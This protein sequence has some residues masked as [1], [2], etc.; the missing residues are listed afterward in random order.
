MSSERVSSVPTANHGIG[1]LDELQQLT[2]LASVLSGCPTVMIHL[3]QEES[4][5]LVTGRQW[6]PSPTHPELPFCR[7][8]LAQNAPTVIEKAHQDSDWAQSPLVAGPWH[9]Q[10]MA[11][12]PI[13]SQQ[14]TLMGL[15]TLLHTEQPHLEKKDYE[16]LSIIARQAAASIQLG[17]TRARI[18]QLSDEHQK[19][20]RAFDDSESFYHNL[21]ESLPQH[22]IRKDAKGCFTFANEN[23]CQAL[24]RD[25]KEILGKDDMD[26]FPAHLA[27]KYRQ[28]DQKVMRTRQKIETTEANEGLNQQTS[29]VHVIK[30]PL[31]DHQGQVVGVQG[32]FWDVTEQITT[33]NDLALERQLLRSL[34]DTI[35]DHV[36]FKDLG[37]RFIRCSRELSDRLGLKDPSEAVGMT[38][39]DFFDPDHAQA[40]YDD[41]QRII[42]TGEPIINKVEKE[43]LRTGQMGWVLTSKMPYLNEQGDIIGTF[44]V[45]KDVTRLVQ[46]EEALRKAEQ[47]Y[48]DI[49]E[50]AVEGIF[51][52]TPEG[53]YLNVNP[54]LARIYGYPSP[55][56]LLQSLT[57]IQSQLYVDP[58]RRET[59]QSIMKAHGEI[60]EF[61]S[62]I[63]HRDGRKIWISETARAVCDEEG[64]ILYYE[65]LVEDISERKRAEAAMEFAR[66]AAMESN[67][68]KSVFLASMSH[69]I[70]TPMNGIIGMT[71]LL[72]QTTLSEEQHTFADTIETSANGLLRL[73]NDLL[74]FSKIESGKMTL[75][76]ASFG[77]QETVEQSVALLADQAQ[78]KGLEVILRLDEQL[79]SQVLGDQVR[80]QQI[81]NNLIGN[82]IKFTKRGEVQ[83]MVHPQK[84]QRDTCWIRFQIKD[85]G[86]GIKQEA[87]ESIFEAF[88]QADDSMTRKYGGTG[89]GLAITRQLIELMHGQLH[90]ESQYGQGSCF[91]FTLP[92][93]VKQT[94]SSSPKSTSYPW[95]GYKVLILEPNDHSQEALAPMLRN[96]RFD[97]HFMTQGKP[98][99][100]ELSRAQRGD[101][102]YDLV[103][104]NAE[105]KDQSGVAFCQTVHDLHLKPNPTM[106]LMAPIGSQHQ[107]ER[108]EEQGIAMV[109]RKP[110][111]Q[112]ILTRGFNRLFKL[113]SDEPEGEST[114]TAPNKN[115]IN[116]VV[117]GSLPEVLVVDDNP[118]NQSVAEHMLK[119]LGFRCGLAESGMQALDYVQKHPCSIILM[120]CQMPE[121]DGYQTTYQV[122][123]MERLGQTMTPSPIKIIAMTANSMDGDRQK[124]LDAGMDDYI[125]KPVLF[126]T[127]A[128]AMNRALKSLEWEV[129]QI[130]PPESI[131]SRGTKPSAQVH[132][133][134]KDGV[135]SPLLNHAILKGYLGDA[136]RPQQSMLARLTTLFVE[137]ELPKRLHEWQACIEG[138]DRDGLRRSAHTLKGSASNMGSVAL[139]QH[140]AKVESE[141]ATMSVETMT[142]SLKILR[143]LAE[144]TSVAL[145]AFLQ[146]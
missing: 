120:D 12:F 103:M 62:E 98:A 61:E 143:S 106:V 66:D 82:A 111:M 133:E 28:D 48:R 80:L 107:R 114:E 39:F 50:K 136:D 93:E 99:I 64:K 33:E 79:P 95:S 52:T 115:S 137:S 91:W 3:C 68:L 109:V 57:D 27:S 97:Y 35:P 40:A 37:S 113:Q 23:F 131:P 63:F 25:L 104:V 36:Y 30:T 20:K 128:S 55:E 145:K 90:V 124:C 88:M 94:R 29:Y 117:Q 102:P 8:A 42:Q 85:T 67:R 45:S 110:I 15:M 77:L 112:G 16:A 7:H 41:E 126:D 9:V 26:L 59:F 32:I 65:G 14:N 138:G 1:S 118:V 122:R 116:P 140:C 130:T 13:R 141:A 5:S 22:I 139:A 86:I 44:G 142:Q 21:V 72:K 100:A 70:R 96:Y 49:F 146:N 2:Q 75:E 81:L 123:S 11:G 121:L 89:L 134:T 19:V 129:T 144:Q 10:F 43:T 87:L 74:D 6:E 101:A 31:Y 83:I 92:M 4:I 73:I 69:E 24:G 132:Q 46:T 17:D 76:A 119:K 60:H 51:Q 105:L 18:T 56:E 125:A 84:I 34:L 58:S 71:S 53:H 135:T 54:A 127:L 38:D 108:L 47:Q 78:K